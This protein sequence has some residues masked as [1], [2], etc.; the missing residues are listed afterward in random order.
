[1]RVFVTGGTGLIGR[2][3]AA[4]L[5]ARGD[6]VVV[7]TRGVER[8]RALPELAGAELVAGDPMLPGDWQ[9]AVDGCDGVINLAGQ[10]VF[11][12]RWNV[13]MRR[14]IR[15]SRVYGTGHVAAAITRARVRP[16]VLVQASAIGYYGSRG[17]EELTESSPPGSGFMPDLCREWEAAAA[18]VEPLGVRRATV[19]VGVVLAKGEGALAAMTPIFKWVPG[20]AAP[21]G[22]GSAWGI[23]RGRQWMSW[24][25]A[26]DIVGLFLLGL[27]DER[28]AGPINGT[29]P[30]PERNVDFSRKLAKVLWRPFLP[31]GPPD[32]LLK[33]ILGDVAEVV[34]TGQ[35]VLPARAL[36]LGYRFRH[37]GLEGALRSV[38]GKGESRRTG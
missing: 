2:R 23:G 1:M 12:G 18:V 33:L 21:V 7:L 11:S 19:R 27:D 28:A 38:F 16:R 29:A 10:N 34:T 6:A 5:R 4:E 24:V 20:G 25:H 13:E 9:G 35:R 30:A 8:A 3:L 36:E 26:D 31:F 22:S 32:G 37:P 17:D 15:D 14:L